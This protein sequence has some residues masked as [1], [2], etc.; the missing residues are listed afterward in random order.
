[1][2]IVEIVWVRTW[3]ISFVEMILS[4]LWG[5]GFLTFLAMLWMRFRAE[6]AVPGDAIEPTRRPA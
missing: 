4:V 5:L 2:V 6:R 1:L 3:S